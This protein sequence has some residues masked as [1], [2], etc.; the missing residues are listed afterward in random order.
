MHSAPAKHARSLPH[1]VSLALALAVWLTAASNASAQATLTLHGGW[2]TSSGLQAPETTVQPQPQPVAPRDVTV[3]DS[4]FGMVVAGWQLDTQRDIEVQISRQRTY[5]TAPGRNGTQTV[6]V[7]VPLT[8]LTVQIGGINFF[9]S[10]AGHG[11]Y[12]AGGV[13]ATRLTPDLAGGI[14]ETRPSLAVA[15]GYAWQF[16]AVS[17]R[18]EARFNTIVL[19]SSGGLFCNG[20]CTLT[21]SGQTL[22]QLEA[23]VGLGFRF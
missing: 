11:P 12:V 16:K 21:V 3:R 19:N 2:R 10:T 4:G 6:P 5:L 22:T 14:S 20:G 7:T 9:E 17:L 1:R 15:L 23:S 18:T 13:G 8:L